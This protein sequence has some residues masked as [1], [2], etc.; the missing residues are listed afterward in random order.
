VAKAEMQRIRGSRDFQE[1]DGI[2]EQRENV[3]ANNR[4][5]RVLRSKSNGKAANKQPEK[6][7]LASNLH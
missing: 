6:R 3:S 1:E 5:V 2:E 7:Y 4:S